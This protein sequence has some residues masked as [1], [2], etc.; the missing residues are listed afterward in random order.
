MG[1]YEENR[2]EGKARGGRLNTLHMK[3]KSHARCRCDAASSR[4]TP[5]PEHIAYE[6]DHISQP[7]SVGLETESHPTAEHRDLP[8]LILV[9]N[10]R[11]LNALPCEDPCNL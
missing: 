8:E 5:N 4:L 2:R 9:G 1:E 7:R 10:S 11:P 6:I 3:T